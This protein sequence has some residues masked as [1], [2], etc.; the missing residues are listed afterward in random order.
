M[1][2]QERNTFSSKGAERGHAN[3]LAGNPRPAP[4]R[5]KGT[6]SLVELA[7]IVSL[8][9][10]LAAFAIPEFYGVRDRA[11]RQKTLV[12]L[13]QMGKA[14]AMY[15]SELSDYPPAG[16]PLTSLGLYTDIAVHTKHFNLVELTDVASARCLAGTVKDLTPLYWVTFCPE[17]PGATED[18]QGGTKQPTCSWDGG[19][20]WY[21]CE[22]KM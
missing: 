20:S 9:L 19:A 2:R 12:S 14:M 13:K 1:P 8:L 4:G 21:P 7:V 5:P 18:V 11:A 6:F 16:F 3:F 10:I 17:P 15:R 22:R